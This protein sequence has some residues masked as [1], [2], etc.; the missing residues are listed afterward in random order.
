MLLTLPLSV[1][2]NVAAF[3]RC[4]LCE[5]RKSPLVIDSPDG[6]ATILDVEFFCLK[7]WG[8]LQGSTCNMLCRSGLSAWSVS[9]GSLG[10]RRGEQG[11]SVD[12][13]VE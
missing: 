2:Q 13:G 10:S 6:P 9:G 7:C 3:L 5:D 12:K 8:R 4:V 1:W 11:S